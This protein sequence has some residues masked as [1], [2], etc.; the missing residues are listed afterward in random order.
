MGN[1][2]NEVLDIGLMVNMKYINTKEVAVLTGRSYDEIL[3][4]ARTG[5]L[6]CHR[7][8][9][10]H[11]RLNVDAVEK[12]FGVQVNKP[13]E[14][15]NE[16][17]DDLT[18]TEFRNICREQQGMFR[19]MIGEPMGVGP[20]RD[21]SKKQISMLVNG[22]KTG[23]NFVNKY[24]F[25]YAKSRVKNM[26]AH[27]TI[28]EYRLFN[29]MLSSQPMAFNLFCPFIQMLENGKGDV[30][31]RIFKAIFPDKFIGEV[32]EVGLEYL[33]TDIK[34]YLNDCTAMDAI[35]RYKD[36]NGK[37]A[38]IAIET[39]YT[40]VLGENTSN[41]DRAQ[42]KYREWIKRIGMFKAEAEAD[43]LSGKKAVTQIYRN[44]LLTECYGIV[45][46]ANRCYSVVLAPAQHPTT[47][48]EVASLKDELLPEYHYKIS[49]VSLEDF[50]K[51]TLKI[52][53]KGDKY[54]FWYFRERYLSYIT[55]DD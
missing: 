37:P 15:K 3:N 12:Y 25:N 42:D 36:T 8:R 38:F 50:I 14:N 13:K 40:D 22:D 5:A 7:T 6:P 28:D 51:I 10:G 49:A 26:Q 31:T 9:R 39:K 20:R 4:L 19:E 55:R 2:D 17:S 1:Y 29:N 27:E 33:H 35:V 30:V 41:K 24:S 11:Y 43:L 52:C 21:S 48:K 18:I 32:T 44:F 53:P 16:K 23:K 47:E 46:N 34:N 54:P 45:E